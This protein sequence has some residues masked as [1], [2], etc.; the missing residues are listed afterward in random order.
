M[1]CDAWNPTESG[2]RALN[3]MKRRGGRAATSAIAALAAAAGRREK[4][5]RPVSLSR[6]RELFSA[7]SAVSALG[8]FLSEARTER[9]GPMKRTSLLSMPFAAL[10]VLCA[11]TAAPAMYHPTLGRFVQRDPAGYTDG[12]GLFEYVQGAPLDSVDPAGLQLNMVQP[13]HGYIDGKPG[14]GAVSTA[15][16]PPQQGPQSQGG[17]GFTRDPTPQAGT[18][19]RLDGRPGRDVMQDLKN[20]LEKLC[21]CFKYDI[22]PTTG[23]LSING[24]PAYGDP[25]S[26]KF[27]CCYYEHMAGCNVVLMFRD[28]DM[29]KEDGTVVHGTPEQLPD[30]PVQLGA[31][32]SG[33]VM[34]VGDSGSP[35]GRATT[36]HELGHATL[37]GGTRGQ[38]IGHTASSAIGTIIGP[39]W[40][41]DP[42]DTSQV[43]KGDQEA[44]FRALD[45]F[46][47][48]RYPDCEGK[49]GK[50]GKPNAPAELKAAIDKIRQLFSTTK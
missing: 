41:S 8:A 27:C 28:R 2:G 12:M 10:L 26:E 30:V 9:T 16:P 48:N 42:I 35:K 29:I 17:R 5:N 18:M 37:G 13:R 22:D 38:I 21:K 40:V 46:G 4:E 43:N 15:T 31:N 50:S 6:T 23:R 19:K 47:R 44:V 34:G 25:P 7:I 24:N 36:T 49:V 14:G 3:R 20:T 45:A 39:E 1:V 11:A 33:G 32:M